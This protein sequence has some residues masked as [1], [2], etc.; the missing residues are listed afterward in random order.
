MNTSGWS[1]KLIKKGTSEIVKEAIKDVK[2]YN[3]VTVSEL[4]KSIDVYILLELVNAIRWACNG[5]INHGYVFYKYLKNLGKL[6]DHVDS[7]H[8]DMMPIG[9]YFKMRLA[10]KIGIW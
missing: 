3:N 6:V 5:R 7:V 10:E 8:K 2:F 9:S 1:K 4:R